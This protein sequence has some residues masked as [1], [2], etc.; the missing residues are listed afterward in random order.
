[1]RNKL[2]V[3][4]SQVEKINRISNVKYYITIKHEYTKEPITEVPAVTVTEEKVVPS[5]TEV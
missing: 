5:P 2:Y 3:H 1:M 4:E